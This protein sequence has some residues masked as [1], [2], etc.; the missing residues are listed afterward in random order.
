MF[1]E[2]KQ[3]AYCFGLFL[4]LQL[5][6]IFFFRICRVRAKWRNSSHDI[7]INKITKHN[8]KNKKMFSIQFP[9]SMKLFRFCFACAAHCLQ[10]Y[11]H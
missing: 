7:K 1:R 9:S 5:I 6:A 11:M 2:M 10:S 8:L 4:F 3:M